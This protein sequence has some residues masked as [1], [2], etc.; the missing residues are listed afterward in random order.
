MTGPVAGEPEGAYDAVVVGAGPAGSVTALAMAKKGAS[1]LLV[2]R[3]TF[4]RPK[5]CGC[6]VNPRALDALERAGQGG[7]A[8]A[9]GA[10]P[11]TSLELGCR[12]RR[13]AVSEPLGVALSRDAFDLALIEAARAAGAE[14]LPATA[15]ALAPPSSPHGREV[16]LRSAGG[17]RVVRGRYVVS[18]TG[19]T[20]ALRGD[21]GAG[22][23][24][25]PR[26][27]AGT[28]VGAGA[29]APAAP[30]G[31][32]RGR[33][34][35][36]CAAEGYVGLVVLEDG[37]LDVAAAFRPEA[38]RRAGGVGPLAER[39][40]AGAKFAPVPDLASLA[41]RGTPGLTRSAR[42]LA[43]GRVFRVGDA[44]G[45]VEPFTGEGMAWAVS[46]AL[47]LAELLGGA[48]G[49]DSRPVERAWGAAYRREV[50]RT[51]FVCR[52]ARVALRHP[53]LTSALVGALGVVP[54]LIRPLVRSIHQTRSSPLGPRPEG[55]HV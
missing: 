53:R 16:R 43:E 44:A 9:L 55:L 40:V 8:D 2:D 35:M 29:V 39:V 25:G 49:E 28:K 26:V 32:D 33:I 7:L 17:E 52:A 10:V 4:P 31:Y 36:A 37:R 18:A 15:A 20:D 42:V 21:G 12:G 23:A 41:W 47:R 11:L 27:A 34:Y 14:F 30:P 13:A 5:V 38:V 45:Y 54:S 3:A 24:R 48:V 19:L 1:V 22:T 46:G 6:C 50:T 51:Q